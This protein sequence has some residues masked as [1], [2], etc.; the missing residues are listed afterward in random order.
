MAYVLILATYLYYV[1]TGDSIDQ[2]RNREATRKMPSS[3]TSDRAPR[4]ARTAESSHGAQT[5]RGRSRGHSQFG[6][7]GTVAPVDEV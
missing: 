1:F 2:E 6:G 5:T 7:R 4:G 3:H